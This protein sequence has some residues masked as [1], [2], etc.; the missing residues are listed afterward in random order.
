MQRIPAGAIRTGILGSRILGRLAP[1]SERDAVGDDPMY[2]WRWRE[3]RVDN[4][5]AIVP[6]S[7]Y[8]ETSHYGGDFGITTSK[9]PEVD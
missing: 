2:P 5:D 9:E 4:Q 7:W 3:D 6:V 1:A 8:N